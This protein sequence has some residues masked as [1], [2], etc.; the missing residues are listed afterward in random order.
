M[1]EPLTLQPNYTPTIFNRDMAIGALLVAA[2]PFT[3]PLGV[4]L[5]VTA[6]A[7]VLSGLLGKIR[8]EREN[9]EGKKAKTP[10]MWNKKTLI[11]GL[12]GINAAQVI[13]PIASA[14]TTL[15]VA[16]GSPAASLLAMGAGLLAGGASVIIPTLVGG[17]MGQVEMEHE[18]Q[19]AL[20][21]NIAKQETKNRT[22]PPEL[23]VAM[24]ASLS[25][26]YVKKLQ[27]ERDKPSPQQQR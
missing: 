14:V 17:R 16:T 21:Q 13:G 25:P 26:E 22:L 4:G 7:G 19:T 12:I 9:V 2:I 8:M 11:G 1:A 3:A 23:E 10:S 5:A 6:A 18:Y 15:L 27:S 24:S 20:L